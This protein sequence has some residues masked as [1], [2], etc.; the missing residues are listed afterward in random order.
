MRSRACCPPSPMAPAAAVRTDA[1]RLL[2]SRLGYALRHSKHALVGA[3]LTRFIE[4]LQDVLDDIGGA[5]SYDKLNL[6][7]APSAVRAEVLLLRSLAAPG[8]RSGSTGGSAGSAAA[9]PT[10]TAA[11]LGD[12]DALGAK[13][14]LLIRGLDLVLERELPALQAAGGPPLHP[15]VVLDLVAREAQCFSIVDHSEGDSVLSE[16]S[17]VTSRECGTQTSPF[18]RPRRGRVNGRG[19]QTDALLEYVLADELA[20][21]T[22]LLPTVAADAAMSVAADLLSSDAAV[23]DF[24]SG[25]GSPSEAMVPHFQ[26]MID[27][28]RPTL[29]EIAARE[30]FTEFMVA[31]QLRLDSTISRSPPASSPTTSSSPP[32]SSSP[33]S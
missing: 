32:A 28:L 6:N 22:S 31:M 30:Q 1:L 24:D 8:S 5:L 23:S 27:A 18:Q 14:D 16:V 21:A 25:E 7:T 10:T 17:A 29:V 11:T 19:V 9:T 33:T 13:M 15:P 26:M 3:D 4:P 12:C 2:A 20:P